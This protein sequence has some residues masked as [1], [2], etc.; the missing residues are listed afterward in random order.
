MHFYISDWIADGKCFTY[1]WQHK[2][3]ILAQTFLQS[4]HK[5]ERGKI[6]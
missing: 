3:H 5:T 2:M 4:N 6:F 1:M